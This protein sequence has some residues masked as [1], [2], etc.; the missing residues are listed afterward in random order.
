M[1]DIRV[2]QKGFTIVE[3]LIVI[4]VV[5]ILATISVVAYSGVQGRAQNIKTMSAVREWSQALQMYKADNDDY[6]TMV[7]CLGAG[8]G[9]G[10]SGN[11]A[12]GG[13]CRQDSSTGGYVTVN[14]TFM[15]LMTQYIKGAPTPAFVTG[16]LSDYPWYR[17]AYFYPGYTGSKDRIDYIL[18]GSATNCPAIAGM[19][20][21]ARVTYPSTNSVLCR[22]SFQDSKF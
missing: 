8:Y 6:P 22:I 5:A 4:V 2:A 21:S 18:A 13:E 11:D 3:L 19:A 1:N 20:S 14:T 16:S 9:K 10:F 17:G 7:S 12:T 15:N